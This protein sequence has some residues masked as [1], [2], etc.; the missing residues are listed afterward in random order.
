[1]NTWGA[2]CTLHSPLE[3]F[4]DVPPNSPQMMV[5]VTTWYWRCQESNTITEWSTIYRYYKQRST[6]NIIP[7]EG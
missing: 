1:M 5:A 7:C 2:L 3:R 6:G 4:V